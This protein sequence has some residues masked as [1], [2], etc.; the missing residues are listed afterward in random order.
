MLKKNKWTVYL[1]RTSETTM[2]RFF[3]YYIFLKG[4][5]QGKRSNERVRRTESKTS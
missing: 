1:M 4:I 5:K 3:F 2:S